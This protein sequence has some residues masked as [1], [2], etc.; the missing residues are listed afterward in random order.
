MKTEKALWNILDS[1]WTT[2]DKELSFAD[3]QSPKESCPE[4]SYPQYLGTHDGLA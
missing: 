3:T 2:L 1:P 4:E